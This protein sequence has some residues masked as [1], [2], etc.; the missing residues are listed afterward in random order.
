MTTRFPL[1]QRAGWSRAGSSAG[2]AGGTNQLYV[3]ILRGGGIILENL[4]ILDIIRPMLISGTAFL[5]L[6][7]NR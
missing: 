7:T 5:R 6:R 2:G 1:L 3:F 4:A